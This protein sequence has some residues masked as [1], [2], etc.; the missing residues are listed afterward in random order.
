MRP[1]LRRGVAGR[2][3]LGLGDAAVASIGNLGVSILAARSTSLHEF[4]VFATTMLILIL[5]TLLSRA[6]HGDVLVLRSAG[7]REDVVTDLRYSL[8]SVVSITS[9]VGGVIATAGLVLLPLGVDPGLALTV[10]V[11]GA[12][13]P[14]L[15][16]QD[17]LRWIEYARGAP[18]RA[19]VNNLIWTVASIVLFLIAQ[20]VGDG[21]LP[22]AVCVL[23]WV[24]G[25]VPA[26]VFAGVRGRI[27]LRF[28]RSE[29]LRSH[30]GLAGNLV[31]DFS[32]TQATA[33]AATL[34]VAALAGPLE[35]AFIRKG[36]IWLGPAT[37]AITGLLAALQPLLARRTATHGNRSTVR[38]AAGVGL[39]AGAGLLAYG[40]LVVWLPETLAE[41]VV[42]PGWADVRPYLWPLAVQAAAGMLGGCLGLALRT[43]GQIGAQVRW[44]LFLAPVS[45]GIVTLVTAV[46]GGR[47]GMWALAGGGL[48]TTAAW[49]L[50]LRRG[51]SV[52]VPLAA[53]ASGG[54]G[55]GHE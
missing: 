53:D 32:L 45:L 48:L 25:A 36:Q 7:D 42:G 39:A 10:V 23:L 49:A 52:P 33:Q 40:G 37:V 21:P 44:R 28:S 34:V 4:G 6:A 5:A 47:A 19:L 35:M 20:G 41:A 18:S 15:C 27:S 14:L 29:W 16:V 54:G 26:V 11:A 1:L 3:V 31:L 24:G 12:A 46:A 9:V 50:L 13:L 2:L 43:T 17:H 22:A 30:R 8:A 38:L 55:G 51:G